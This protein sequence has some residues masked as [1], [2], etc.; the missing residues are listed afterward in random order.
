MAGPKRGSRA[1]SLKTSLVP[2]DAVTVTTLVD[3]NSDLLLADQGPVTRAGLLGAAA[4]PRLA[5]NV[6]DTGEAYD[7]PL[8]EHGF[9]MLVSVTRAGTD[10]HLLFDAGMTST[11][12]STTCA[13]WP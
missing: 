5:T 10:H 6:L 4:A 3:N 8:A 11:A 9:A 13:A 12:W 1:S 7:V 2:V